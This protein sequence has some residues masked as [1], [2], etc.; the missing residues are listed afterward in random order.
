MSL[1]SYIGALRSRWPHTCATEPILRIVLGNESC[2][3]DSFAS[4]LTYAYTRGLVPVL[5]LPDSR[6]IL[7]RRDIAWWLSQRGIPATQLFT[8]QD[9]KEWRT[10]Q[11][12][13]GAVHAVL[14][15]HNKLTGP[16]A[17]LV[18]EVTGVVDHHAD[19]GLYLGAEPR[20]VQPCA[21]CSTLVMDLCGRS[22]DT[23]P[24]EDITE[25]CLSALL[26]DSS[27]LAKRMTPL[28]AS[29]VNRFYKGATDTALL[30]RTLQGQK[31][32]LS[33]LTAGDVLRADYKQFSFALGP[34]G[35]AVGVASVPR[36]LRWAASAVGW[37]EF[38]RAAQG[39]VAD[40]GLALLLVM[41]HSGGRRQ[42]A[43]VT[44]SA[45]AALADTVVAAVAGDL[46]L[47]EITADG[48]GME[49]GSAEPGDGFRGSA[50]RCFEQGNAVVSR[51]LF[52]PMLSRFFSSLSHQRVAATGPS[53]ATP[54]RMKSVSVGVIGAGVVGSALL[55]Q[56]VALSLPDVQLELV[57]VAESGKAL[58]SQDYKPLQNGE[59]F[60][61]RDALAKC[62]E[63]TGLEMPQVIEF[64]KNSPHRAILVDNTSSAYVAGFYND[65][66]SA[67]ISIATPNK[68][69]F[70]SDIK[71]WDQ[72]FAPSTDESYPRGL[73]YH[74]ATVG[75]GLPIISFLRE[76]IAT[77]DQ[78]EKIEGIFSGTL[79][80]I[81]N[82]FSSSDAKFSEI[83]AVAKS[84]GYTEPDPRDDLNG[85][86]VAR[87]VTI[88]ARIAGLPVENPQAFPVQS[89]IPKPLESVSSAQEFLEKLP[90]YDGDLEALKQEAAS[91]GKVLRFI[92]SVDL[93]TKTASVGI[94]KYDTAHPFASL[95]GSDNVI[96]IKTKR[97]T[98]PVVIQ[99][100]G[101]GAAV[102][103]AG[104]LGDAIKAAQ[105][106]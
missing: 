86:D 29:V 60:Q 101:A 45:G 83:V 77:G 69:A 97:Y 52:T 32:D 56:L 27:C 22:E 8:L 80:Y 21:S 89:L 105:R 53:R 50:V 23:P 24:P 66:V 26:L 91:E 36:S 18:D 31:R 106:L 59:S 61:W 96:S 67:G 62:G 25:L 63:S 46:A 28:D 38:C 40:R 19:E 4:T 81:F 65:F 90:Q 49:G 11:G 17:A 68:K 88:V 16:A 102:T 100:A 2:D 39:A 42:L 37:A 99:G 71:V 93:T 78:V 72:L 12:P 5:Q 9:V 1:R 85:L 58:L 95:K 94:Q 104:V 82:E 51:K 103:A 20:V 74:E 30:Y 75:A 3:F 43:V 41:F 57:L 79:S 92:G 35:V 47:A 15:D 54:H 87:K 98:N 44:G 73:V 6:D 14:V 84:L 34:V 7:L 33:G 48:A 64:L 76:I 10:T 13:H 55:D 70:S